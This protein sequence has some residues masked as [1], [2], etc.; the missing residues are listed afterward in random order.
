MRL[1]GR[2]QTYCSW[3]TLTNQL[4]GTNVCDAALSRLDADATL[5]PSLT[6]RDIAVPR[7]LGRFSVGIATE[8]TK[9]PQ[10]RTVRSV[11]LRNLEPKPQHDQPGG[12]EAKRNRKSNSRAP[13][14]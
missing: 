1:K 11:W 12:T 7:R 4:L 14:G 9:F 8:R 3:P 13:E 2:R 5:Q 6:R 10:C